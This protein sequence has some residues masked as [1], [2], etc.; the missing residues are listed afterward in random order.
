M[1]VEVIEGVRLQYSLTELIDRLGTSPLPTKR[2]NP[3][4]DQYVC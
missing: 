3:R 4:L 2:L 1:G